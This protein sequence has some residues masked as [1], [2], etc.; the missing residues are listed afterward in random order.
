MQ[1][2]SIT[3]NKQGKA[4]IVTVDINLTGTYYSVIRMDLKS[5]Y[6]LIDKDKDW[7]E[8]I[9]DMSKCFSVD[10]S[11]IGIV[12]SLYKRCH[13]SKKKF[14][15]I[16]CNELLYETF[17]A[18]GLVDIFKV[19]KSQESN[20]DSSAESKIFTYEKKGTALIFTPNLNLT[21]TNIAQQRRE[22][23]EA[24][25]KELKSDREWESIIFDLKKIQ[26][27]DSASIGILLGIFRRTQK[28][29]KEFEVLGCN[30]EIF[31]LLELTGLYQLF[32]IKPANDEA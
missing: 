4:W 13:K 3:A 30:E 7:E 18:S 19:Q 29:G 23:V 25:G 5:A 22:L 24:F 1:E 8:M 28:A 14:S 17:K 15:I 27:I 6:G 21:I 12:V 31:Q 10:S 16:R 9:L 26:D 11:G 32:S 2:K 20:R